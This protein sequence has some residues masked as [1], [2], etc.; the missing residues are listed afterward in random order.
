MN[1][2]K[3]LDIVIISCLSLF[4]SSWCHALERNDAWRYMTAIKPKDASLR[5]LA[6]FNLAIDSN[7]LPHII[8]NAYTGQ[9]LDDMDNI[10]RK[11]KKKNKRK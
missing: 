11:G 6:N 3:F 7:G 5:G 9:I 8:F 10:L 4:F 1:G 2:N